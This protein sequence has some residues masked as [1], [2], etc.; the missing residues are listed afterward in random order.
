MNNAK[1]KIWECIQARLSGKSTPRKEA[2]LK[3]WL[4]KDPANR[5]IFNHLQSIWERTPEEDFDVNIEKAWAQFKKNQITE[6]PAAR[7]QSSSK[8]ITLK[9][10]LTRA[11]AIIL[12]V[13][14]I[15][16]FSYKYAYN[17]IAPMENRE[18]AVM[19]KVVTAKGEK[20]QVTFTDGTKVILNVAS[21]LRYPKTFSGDER[22]VYL[23]GEA[24]FEV[25]P[26]KDFPFVVH[27]QD[28]R[29]KVLG[30]K[31]N[32]RAWKED[33]QSLIGVSEGEV[34]VHPSDSK[35]KQ[36][37]EVLLTKN[38]RS[39]VKNGIAG[40]AESV[41]A[42]N[43]MLWLNGGLYFNKTPFSEATRQI[44]RQF[45]VQISFENAALAN[46]PFT[47]TFK[48]AELEEVLKIISASMGIEYRREG[49]YIV[50]KG[51]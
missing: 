37:D 17:P 48:N 51:K 33:K 19:E 40:P 44:E 30:T 20:A 39:T 41:D 6:E 8:K 22:E 15:G 28:A 27:T 13:A 14:C 32:I 4:N 47:G 36:N 38:M 3:E 34:V 5:E 26:E 23:D 21:S 29:V 10:F 45:D 46:V 49:S 18:N 25:A 7:Y 12:L 16:V 9:Y 43:L 50:F 42:D 31:F 35:A 11:A 24:Y 1:S 2:M